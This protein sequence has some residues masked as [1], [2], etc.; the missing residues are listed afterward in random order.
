MDELEHRLRS[1]LTEMAEEVPP[2]HGAWE[3]QQRRLA[4]KS[5][6][7]RRRPAVMAAVAAAVVALIAI[8]VV[9]IN[10]QIN[11][12]VEPAGSLPWVANPP[13]ST[14]LLPPSAEVRYKP[15]YIPLKGEI[16]L[17]EPM[18]IDTVFA[19]GGKIATLTYAYTVQ[20]DRNYRQMC[21]ARVPED[22][23]VINGPKQAAYGDPE[24]MPLTVPKVGRYEWGRWQVP[25]T[26]SKGLWLYAMSQPADSMM[27]LRREGGYVNTQ[28][29]AAGKDI[30]LFVAYMGTTIPP[31]QFSVFD[32][33][34]KTL[35]NGE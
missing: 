8:P 9:I 27:F 4:L 5:R 6:R 25:S 16:L 11:A 18:N 17:T 34:H 31:K 12:P 10:Q 35:M 2:S 29:K 13:E 24:C 1:A 21:V 20:L 33:D 15:E 32:S 28:T 26:T 22:N 23:P 19:A 3:E 7:D 14:K 30:V